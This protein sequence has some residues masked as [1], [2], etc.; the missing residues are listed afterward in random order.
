MNY[1]REIG[2][3]ENDWLYNVKVVM[4]VN[5]ESGKFKLNM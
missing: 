1:Y 2:T 4:V 3:M 5:Y